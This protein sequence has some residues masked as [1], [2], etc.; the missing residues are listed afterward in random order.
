LGEVFLDVVMQSCTE[1]TTKNLQPGHS[2]LG[3]SH[4]PSGLHYV[5]VFHTDSVVE[6]DSTLLLGFPW[7][8]IFKPET[9]KQSCLRN[10]KLELKKIAAFC[11]GENVT[12]YIKMAIV[13]E[14]AM[15]VL[16]FFETKSVLKRQRRYRTQHGKDRPSYIV[17]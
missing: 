4:I 2:T 12:S 5:S 7:R 3:F 9:I 11:I 13:Q 15:C 8:I 17:I 14:K 10:M 6:S 1:E 16:R